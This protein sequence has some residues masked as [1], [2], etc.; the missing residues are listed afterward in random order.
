ML[1]T[2][3]VPPL[4]LMP[5]M[6]GFRRCKLLGVRRSGQLQPFSSLG[7]RWLYKQGFGR[8]AAATEAGLC[9]NHLAARDVLR[10]AASGVIFGMDDSR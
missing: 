7:V 8:P 6:H 10:A 2:F 4:Y 1:G 9:R 5:L 3:F